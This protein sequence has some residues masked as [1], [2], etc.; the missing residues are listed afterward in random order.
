MPQDSQESEKI[1]Y[2]SEDDSI[3]TGLV[4]VL[5]TS[6]FTDTHEFG[7]GG[8]HTHITNRKSN[9]VGKEDDALL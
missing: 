8:G 9:C 4:Y 3:I 1:T 2:A 7:G 5:K 6:S